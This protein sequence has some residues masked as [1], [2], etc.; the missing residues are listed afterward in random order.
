MEAFDNT[1][2]SEK[3]TKKKQFAIWISIGIALCL[4]IYGY[5]IYEN[6][7]PSTDDAYVQAHVVDVAAQISGPIE[8]IYV[9]N[10]Q[11]VKKGQLLLK[12]D[13]RPFAAAVRQAEAQLT[14]AQQAMEADVAAV[15]VAKA[16]VN[17]AQA[18]FIVDQKNYDRTIT[19][20]KKGEASIQSG[21]DAKG[22][23]Q[24][25]K[26]TLIASKQQLIQA[27]KNL[28]EIGERNAQIRQA[29]ANL[30]TA[31]L[32]LSYTKLFAPAEGYVTNFEV[33]DGSMVSAQQSLFKF[34]ETAR[35]YVY[36]NYKET[37]MARIH[38]NQAAKITLD[39]YPDHTYHGYVDSISR[40]SGSV[41]SL[42][43]PENA[44]GNWVKVTQRFPVK[45]IITDPDEKFPLRVG[46][47]STVKINTLEKAKTNS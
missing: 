44:T 15:A 35:W 3:K 32:N 29:Q 28:G 47:S 18:Q 34:V 25:A 42:L 40:G 37:Q 5:F 14:L 46:A 4:L 36:A 30:D 7:F 10:N 12:I 20:V 2:V 11:Y 9:R 22:D 21:D 31:K 43:P 1:Q 23:L 16:N 39:M 38:K 17:K 41:F 26:A 27:Q 6:Y 24:S 8:H 19:L 13:P 33:R 45:I